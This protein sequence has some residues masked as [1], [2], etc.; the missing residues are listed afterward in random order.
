MTGAKII[1]KPDE[2]EMHWSDLPTT[3]RLPWGL[4]NSTASSCEWIVD[5]DGGLLGFIDF[6]NDRDRQ[7]FLTQMAK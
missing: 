6:T 7:T 4:N 5:A 1:I 2:K 3:G